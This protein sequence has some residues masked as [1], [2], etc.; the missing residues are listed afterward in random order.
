MPDGETSSHVKDRVAAC[1]PLGFARVTEEIQTIA[2][3][4]R[5]AFLVRGRL[6]QRGDMIF[7]GET[8]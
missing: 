1:R 5:D 7:V 8:P 3:H 2:D 6:E 4:N